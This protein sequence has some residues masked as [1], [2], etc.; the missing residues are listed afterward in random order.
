MVI[1]QR[2]AR[3]AMEPSAL[4]EAPFS[5]VRAG[6][7]EALFASKSNVIEGIF[8]KLKTLQPERIADVG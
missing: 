4:Y 7:H 8:E 2:T 1:D 5:N 6:G 3:G